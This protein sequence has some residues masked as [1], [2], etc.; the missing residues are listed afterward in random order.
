M[1]FTQ[2]ALL[3]K[4]MVVYR[5]ENGRFAAFTIFNDGERRYMDARGNYVDGDKE[6][7]IVTTSLDSREITL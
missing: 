3:G 4:D 1:K 2:Q 5:L 7:I 6:E